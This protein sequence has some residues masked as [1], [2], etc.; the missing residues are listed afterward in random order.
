[1]STPSILDV[2]RERSQDPVRGQDP[3]GLRILYNPEGRRKAGII[4]AHG[5]GGCWKIMVH[6]PN[7]PMGKSVRLLPKGGQQRYES[8]DMV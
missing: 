8:F 2:P 5:L 4:C 3:L 6:S 7:S 1:M